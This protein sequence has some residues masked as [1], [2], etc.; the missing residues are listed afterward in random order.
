MIAS[1]RHVAFGM[2]FGLA[3]GSPALAQTLPR[4][5]D[6]YVAKVLEVF[7][8]PGVSL[9]IVKDGSVALSRG[10]GVRRLGDPARVDGKTAF[11]IA[12]N[13]KA[14][15]GAAIALLAEEGKL[16]WDDPV[17]KHLPA[18]QMY[19][20]WVT[21]EIQVAELLTHHSG[22][23]LGQGDLLYFPASKLGR[24]E[25]VRR[26]R[27]LAPATSFRSTYAYD[28]ILYVVADQLVEAVSGRPWDV[29][30]K[31]RI[32]GPLGMTSCTTT[33]VAAWK[34]GDNVAT[35]HAPVAGKVTPVD[36]SNIDALRAAGGINSCTDE[37]ARWAMAQ[38]GRGQIPGSGARL[39]SEEQS[40]QMWSPQTILA[41]PTSLPPQLEPLRPNFSAYGSG[42][43]LLDYAGRKIVTHDGG[44]IGE[45][46]RVVLVPSEG[47]GVV[48][49][50]NG[51]E[52]GV[53]NAIGWH[54]LDFYLKGK[55]TDW[56]EPFRTLR[57]A[58]IADAARVEATAEAGRAKASAPSLDIASYAGRFRDAW[59]GEIA[60]AVENGKLTFTAPDSPS[61][62]GTLDH[63]QHDTFRAKWRDPTIPDAFVTFALTPE[64]T[65]DSFKMQ[66]VSP[67][68][69]FSFDYQDLLF[70]PVT[71]RKP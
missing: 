70:R 10:Y 46:S 62:T 56:V 28:N 63:W 65:V 9:A 30:V 35:P 49:L 38:L 43:R 66:A 36:R 22:L 57:D 64:G 3:L 67:L 42:W 27:F 51:E 52:S 18:F 47:L 13:T 50:T 68:A 25:I 1:V 6:A 23:G 2:A 54:V 32:L 61:L 69:D 45:V 8:T 26:L 7:G 21:R 4:G 34:P 16:A 71:K 24:D 11:G 41:I 48:I 60:L 39:F 19:D 59:F 37:M 40:A 29:F 44:L 12:S 53:L 33:S 31:A 55:D 58:Q 5:L 14:F 15:T 17:V 20:P